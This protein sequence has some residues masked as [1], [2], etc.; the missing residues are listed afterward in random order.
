MARDPAA[1]II[2]PTKA[3]P[4][5]QITVYSIVIFTL[6]VP[7]LEKNLKLL[8]GEA[9]F[10]DEG[11][12]GTPID[13]ETYKGMSW[14]SYSKYCHTSKPYSNRVQS[15]VRCSQ[16]DGEFVRW[17]GAVNS[18]EILH[19]HNLKRD[20]LGFVYPRVVRNILT[21]FFGE[22]NAV[23]CGQ[24]ENDCAGMQQHVEG[25][26]RCNLNKWDT[27]TYL[28]RMRMKS[29]SSTL[30]LIGHFGNLTHLTQNDKLWFEG[31]L[32]SRDR[33]IYR[34]VDEPPATIIELQ[35]VG[36][37]SCKSTNAQFEQP[38]SP[39]S[40]SSLLVAVQGS[41]KHLLNAIFNPVLIFK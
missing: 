3:N 26:W 17:E 14:E 16:L 9:V 1:R 32:L 11:P 34:D 37:V 39:G 29:P 4:F 10:Q 12:L 30:L 40:V 6:V 38:H 20:L 28:V 24:G 31:G 13:A 21:C 41:F 18:V 19:V 2:S 25:R 36:C 8:E 5:F 22:A 35:R 27:Y 23:D 15:Q 33:T 7:Y